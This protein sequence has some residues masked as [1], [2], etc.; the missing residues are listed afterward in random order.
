M[1]FSTSQKITLFFDLRLFAN[2]DFRVLKKRE[3]NQ[4]YF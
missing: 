2:L 4:L 1:Y 3:K